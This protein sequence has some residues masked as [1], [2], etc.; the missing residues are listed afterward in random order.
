MRKEKNKQTKNRY[1]KIGGRSLA[2][3]TIKKH[4]DNFNHQLHLP[5]PNSLEI[6][7]F[8]EMNTTSEMQ[9]ASS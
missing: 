3:Q 6:L 2:I 8:S 7:D 9:S 1:E 5:K 4:E